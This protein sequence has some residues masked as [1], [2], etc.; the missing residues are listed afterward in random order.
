[1]LVSMMMVVMVRGG[2]VGRL[3]VLFR[4][5][6]WL[7]NHLGSISHFLRVAP[8]VIV[9]VAATAAAPAPAAAATRLGRRQAALCTG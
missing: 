6:V 3:V 7:N 5:G 1:M 2:R 4:L 8:E 9:V